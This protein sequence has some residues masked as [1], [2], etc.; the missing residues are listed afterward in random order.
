MDINS[1]ALSA[2]AAT[3]ASRGRRERTEEEKAFDATVASCVRKKGG[4]TQKPT[5]RSGVK[6]LYTVTTMAASTRYGGNRTVVVCDSFKKA[7]GIVLGNY[8]DIY[9]FSYQLCVIEA[10][11]CNRLYAYLDEAY[12]YRWYG[13]PN[14]RGSG[15]RAIHTP[16]VYANTFGFGVG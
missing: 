1:N 6:R 4:H 8:G 12:W 13:D 5:T 2:V 3:L 15:Y 16:K 9:E 10:I 11:A 14:K 7:E